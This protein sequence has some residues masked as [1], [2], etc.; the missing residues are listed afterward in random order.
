MKIIW[1][2]RLLIELQSS[3]KNQKNP[4]GPLIGGGIKFQSSIYHS[5]PLKPVCVKNKPLPH[6]ISVA[7]SVS[8]WPKLK[9]S[10]K[11]YPHVQLIWVR[12]NFQTSIYYSFPLKP[13]CILEI[14]IYLISKFLKQKLFDLTFLFFSICIV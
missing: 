9:R 11:S 2:S 8:M 3:S 6:R 13:G 10:Y 14:M 4:H 7:T 5:F 1:L 12:I